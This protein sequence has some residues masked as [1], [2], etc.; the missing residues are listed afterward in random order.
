MAASGG[1]VY[2]KTRNTGSGKIEVHILSRA[3]NYENFSV[4]RATTFGVEDNGVWGIQ[5]SP[6]L[7]VGSVPAAEGTPSRHN[8]LYYIKTHGTG[9]GTVEVH[10]DSGRS[11][12]SRREISVGTTFP[13]EG[14]GVFLMAYVTQ[15]GIDQQH[16]DLVCIKT[17]NTG[18]GKVEIHMNK[19]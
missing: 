19:Y 4:H 11:N 1:L 8:D 6:G 9:T 3:S 17:R 18:S 14:D 12:W 15:Q 13:L 16:P 2:I 10:M 7:P 5:L